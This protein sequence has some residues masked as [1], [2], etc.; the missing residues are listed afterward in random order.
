MTLITER[1]SSLL[2]PVNV[3]EQP[4]EECIAS[5][6]M[7]LVVSVFRF[8]AQSRRKHTIYDLGSGAE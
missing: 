2:S 3:E 5:R 4:R 8:T 6:T 7:E 1:I